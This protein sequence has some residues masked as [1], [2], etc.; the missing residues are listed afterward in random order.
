MYE[1]CKTMVRCT[2]GVTEES[3]VGLLRGLVLSPF[4]FPMVMDRLIDEVRRE[5]PWTMMLA[6]DTV[7]CSQSKWGKC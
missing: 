4:L 1:S 2:V 7:I 6:D 5:S 3:K